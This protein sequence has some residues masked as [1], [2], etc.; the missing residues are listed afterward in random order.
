MPRKRSRFSPPG[1]VVEGWSEGDGRC[2][3][4]VLATSRHRHEVNLD[5]SRWLLARSLAEEIGWPDKPM[6][7]LGY[8][9]GIEHATNC[10]H[11]AMAEE[12]M[13]VYSWRSITKTEIKS[14]EHY[15]G[16]DY[17]DEQGAY[18]CS[19]AMGKCW[20]KMV[21]ADLSRAEAILDSETTRWVAYLDTVS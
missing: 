20:M 10:I 18:W 6:L 4:V 21:T 15:C 9:F 14:G 12:D 5:Q 16:S 7:D 2:L 1:S 8:P 19:E 11:E 3:N 13:P 17:C